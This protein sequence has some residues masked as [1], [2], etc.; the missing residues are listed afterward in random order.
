MEVTSEF[1]TLSPQNRQRLVLVSEME[2]FKGAPWPRT[3]IS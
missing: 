1:G 2:A 3:K